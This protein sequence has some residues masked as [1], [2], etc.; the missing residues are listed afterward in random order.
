M[1]DLA[2]KQTSL[3]C[4]MPPP[5]MMYLYVFSAIA[6]PCPL[7]QQIGR[8]KEKAEIFL[9]YCFVIG[10]SIKLQKLIFEREITLVMSN[11]VKFGNEPI[12]FGAK[13]HTVVKFLGKINF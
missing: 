13:F 12:Y 5:I 10:N 8:E 7:L 6:H 9:E 4:A 2:E 3:T 1:L 11:N